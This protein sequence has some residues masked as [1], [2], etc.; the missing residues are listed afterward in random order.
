MKYLALYLNAPLQSWGVGAKFNFRPSM[1]FPSRSG[2]VGMLAA[3]SGIDRGDDVWLQEVN[4]LSFTMS[5]FAHNDCYGTRIVDYHTVGGGNDNVVFRKKDPWRYRMAVS[6]FDGGVKTELTYR[7]YL[8]DS[9]FGVIIFGD[10]DLVHTVKKL[11]TAVQSPVWGVWLGRKSCIPTE[12]IFAGLYDDIE[13]AQD[14]IN[15]RACKNDHSLQMLVEE[16]TTDQAEENI[17]DIPISFS[18]REY[19]LRSVETIAP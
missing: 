10:N 2:I 18:R 11:A 9:S 7:E 5:V 17:M 13:S 8:Q 3:A 6:K 12:P 16:V 1:S 4:K 14:A 15:K 19:G